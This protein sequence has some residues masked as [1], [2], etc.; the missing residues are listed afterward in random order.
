MET[1]VAISTIMFALAG[2]AKIAG[3]E[4][5]QAQREDLKVPESL[6]RIIGVLE[7]LGAAGVGGTLLGLVP[8]RLGLLAACGFVGLMTGAVL[9]RLRA[10]SNP[11]L[12]IFDFAALGIAIATVWTLKT[13]AY[14]P[15]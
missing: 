10:K 5:S 2:F 8:H 14:V 6:W 15:T 9:T 13:M 11:G 12:I 4:A 7:L 3:L 1:L